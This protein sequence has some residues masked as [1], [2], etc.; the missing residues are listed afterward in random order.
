MRHD[1]VL[2]K[3]RRSEVVTPH[4]ALSGLRGRVAVAVADRGLGGE[5][6]TQDS[7]S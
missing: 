7:Q 5:P 2:G 4:R 6:L 3:G 1:L